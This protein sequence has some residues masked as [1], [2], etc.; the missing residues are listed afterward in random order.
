V[1][2]DR[3][4]VCAE[5]EIGM[6]TSLNREDR[7]AAAPGSGCRTRKEGDGSVAAKA[8]GCKHH[9][10]PAPAEEAVPKKSG[11]GCKHHDPSGSTDADDGP[12]SPGSG[13][14]CRNMLWIRKVHSGAGLVF[15]AFLAEHL[16]ATALGLKPAIGGRYLEFLRAAV[17]EAPWLHVAVYLPMLVVVSFG[18][19]LLAT[20]GLRYNVKKC[21]RGGKLRYW[22]QRMTGLAILAFLGFHLVSLHDFGARVDAAGQHT[23]E[24]VCQAS[25]QAFQAAWPSAES[26]SPLRGLAVLGVL[27][28]TWAAVFHASNGAWS[29]AIAWGLVET[30]A[31]RDRWQ[32]VCLAAGSV[33]AVLGTMG[34]VAF[35]I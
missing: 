34:W 3:V 33:L 27:F 30:P 35:C 18:L 8:C 26:G 25:V 28:G 7:P 31:A 9:A 20:A 17:T 5:T 21:N 13:C 14:T 23:A 12:D 11:C 2:G 6:P 4:G 16:A 29:A 19:Y 10:E 1:F 15:G 32:W 24:S 22:S